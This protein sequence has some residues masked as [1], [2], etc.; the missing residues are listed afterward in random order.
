MER[1]TRRTDAATGDWTGERARIR[2]VR[3][4]GR[5]ERAH[6][7]TCIPAR[8]SPL[9]APPEG[10][11]GQ[12]H[13][14]KERAERPDLGLQA[15]SPHHSG[16]GQGSRPGQEASQSLERLVPESKEIPEEEHAAEGQLKGA[17]ACQPPDDSSFKIMTVAF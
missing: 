4:E 12:R 15:L 16:A 2:D 10:R 5:S 14:H 17:P 1:E 7:C 3:A 11:P 13:F 6:A 9:P 8:S